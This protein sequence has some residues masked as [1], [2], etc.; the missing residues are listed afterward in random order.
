MGS[1]KLQKTR[2]PRSRIRLADIADRA[3][4][5]TATVDRVIHHRPGVKPHTVAHIERV[6]RE[7]A[8]SEPPAIVE[9]SPAPTVFDVILPKGPNFYF[10]ILEEKLAGSNDA[11][12]S[13]RFAVHR[14]EGF[15][16]EA[17]SR[18]I[19]RHSNRSMGLAVVAIEDPLVHEAIAEAV[20]AGIPVV[21]LVSGLS[22]GRQHAY[23]GLNNRAAGRTAGY[24]M[25]RFAPDRGTILMIAGS[26]SLRDHEEREIG[27][28][29]VLDEHSPKLRIVSR[30][31]DH[32]DYRTT[33]R[34]AR[35]F[36]ESDPDLVGIYN[37]GA[38]N[39]GIANA[40]EESARAADI[41]FIGHELTAYTRQY[42]IANVMDA[43][44]DQNPGALVTELRDVLS[45]LHRD[46][47]QAVGNRIQ[48]IQVYFRENL[49]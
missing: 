39:R 21:T 4:V 7:M 25:A 45:S 35:R 2:Q 23:V 8:G 9:S 3:G 18:A 19:R 27:F 46:P 37:I 12:S 31:E 10:N 22:N 24:L 42:L 15:N 49:P 47:R 33:Y 20:D 36:L 28:R 32:D 26:M 16:P 5:S 14:V 34:E 1:D 48:N 38:G 29:R 44:I 43:V 41:T 17:L 6:M 30:L 40:L 11:A 13:S